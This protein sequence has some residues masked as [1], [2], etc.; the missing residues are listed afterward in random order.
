MPQGKKNP[1]SFFEYRE[2]T[3]AGIRNPATRIQ[4]SREWIMPWI[5]SIR[6]GAVLVTKSGAK[7]WVAVVVTV[8]NKKSKEA[9]K[10]IKRHS[11]TVKRV[12]LLRL[13][14]SQNSW[15]MS[16]YSFHRLRSSLERPE[17][18]LGVIQLSCQS[19]GYFVIVIHMD[20]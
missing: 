6:P 20:W 1:F 12:L 9:T 11:N 4:I 7:T 18:S 3:R 19:F 13:W 17:M 8:T 2:K 14:G 10:A 15:A 16:R 5:H